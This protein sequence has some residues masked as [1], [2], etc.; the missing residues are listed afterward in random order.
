MQGGDWCAGVRRL[1]RDRLLAWL[2][3]SGS[4]GGLLLGLFLSTDLLA[5]DLE[6]LPQLAGDALLRFELELGR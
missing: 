6:V 3:A 1:R 2:F 4:G 5:L